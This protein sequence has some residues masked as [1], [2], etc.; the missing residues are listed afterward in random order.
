MACATSV[1]SGRK[2]GA[3]T[4]PRSSS[5]APSPP[6]DPELYTG[7]QWV[8]PAVPITSSVR[9]A[10]RSTIRIPSRDVT[11]PPSARRRSSV[12]PDSQGSFSRNVEFT[13]VHGKFRP[14]KIPS[15]VISSSKLVLRL[16]IRSGMSPRSWNP[17]DPPHPL[18]RTGTWRRLT[19]RS[20]WFVIPYGEPGSHRTGKLVKP[21]LVLAKPSIEKRGIASAARLS[22]PRNRPQC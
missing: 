1:A 11:V 19:R 10:S 16:S 3:A 14:Y 17:C 13:I 2:P 20:R 6:A 4:A 21:A 8:N 5:F 12:V 18:S 7:T 22:R 15:T 9:K